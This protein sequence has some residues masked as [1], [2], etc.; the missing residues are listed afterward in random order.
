[1]P[2]SARPDFTL[3]NGIVLIGDVGLRGGSL[4]L[5][6]CAREISF[7][8]TVESEDVICDPIQGIA[9][10]IDHTP[11]ATVT[12]EELNFNQ[13]VLERALSVATSAAGA[14]DS[15]RGYR[16]IANSAVD[17]E[18]H[19]LPTTMGHVDGPHAPVYA[20]DGL[21]VDQARIQLNNAL[22][23][24]S[25]AANHIY[26][27]I[28]NAD[29]TFAA[30]PTPL[31]VDYGHADTNLATGEIVIDQ[32][33][34]HP[35]PLY[36]TYPFSPFTPGSTILRNPWQIFSVSDVWLR[37][38]HEHGNGTDLIV[39]DFWRARARPNASLQLKTVSGDRVVPVPLV[40]DVFSDARYHPGSP[41]Y[42]ITIDEIA[43]A[44]TPDYG[45]EG[46][47]TASSIA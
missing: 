5:F 16:T 7:D 28:R 36:F 34:T 23:L 31:S 8:Q 20:E 6:C 9:D 18:P 37:I 42:E 15:A 24:A 12:I 32:G 38:L 40:F 11:R 14:I 3:S 25:G 21:G 27:W 46:A 4:D 1:M 45:C 30:A 10:R 44:I 2:T 22:I 33:A 39:F 26:A 41:L 13:V 35:S 29:G 17:D 47:A 43:R 19:T